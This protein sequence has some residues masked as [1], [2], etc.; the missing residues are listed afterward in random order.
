MLFHSLKKPLFTL[1][2]LLL[3]VTLLFPLMA[4]SMNAVSNPTAGR[5]E[6]QQ[7]TPVYDAPA[8]LRIPPELADFSNPDSE[9]TVELSASAFV[10]LL[11][12]DTL[13]NAESSYLDSML[14][15]RPFQYGNAIPIR[16]VET[17]YE[18]NTLTIIAHPHSYVAVNGE[19]VTWY[20]ASATLGGTN[21]PLRSFGTDG[22]KKCILDN[23]PESES[24]RL[25]VRYTC[26]V[27]V[28]P[29]VADAYINYAWS[30]ADR[31]ANTH[32]AYEAHL[33]A[34]EAYCVYLTEKAA[35]DLAY[36]EWQAYLVA[37][38]KYDK[39]QA[40][41]T[42][43]E[44]AMKVY[45]EQL[46]AYEAYQTALRDY[47]QKQIAYEQ[48]YA[49]YVKELNAYNEA[50]PLYET[51]QAQLQRAADILATLDSAYVFNS[52]GKQM[53]ATLIGDTVA[54]VV[55]RKSE[56]V[57][58]GKCDPK[59]IDT[60]AVS[61]AILQDLLTQYKDI[62]E[63]PDRFAFYRT[64]YSEI[65]RNFIDLYG[66]LRSLYNNEVVKS[67]LIN[68]NKLERF[69]EFLSQLYVISTGLDDTQNRADDWV[70]YGRYDSAYFG[71]KPHTFK[72]ELEPEQIP[73]D[74]NNADPTG[75]TCPP[76]VLPKPT[77]P[78][79]T[80]T[81]PQKP[82]EVIC[83]VEPDPVVK[84]TPPTPIPEPTAPTPVDDPGGKPI[85]PAYTALQ[86]QLMAAHKDGTLRHRSADS[87]APLAL[88]TTLPRQLSLHNK[89]PVE[90]YDYDG[91]TLLFS[92]EL[93]DNAPIAYGG[94]TP[95][96]PDSDKYTYRFVGWK[97][98]DG[99][100]VS[101][102][103]V[104]DE[105]HEVFYASY[106]ATLR[107]Y[108]VTWR[109][110][111]E[112]IDTLLPYGSI[113]S[114]EG[115]P[116]KAPTEQYEYV[117]T[118]WRIPGEDGWSTDLVAILTD[119]TYEAVFEPILRRYTVTWIYGD[120]EADT[121]SA[122]WE[123]GTVPSPDRLPS[124][125][126]DE[127]YLYEFAGWSME[128]SAVTGD[129]SYTAQYTA[130]P[131]LP[132][133]DGTDAPSELP[134]APILHEDVY[135]ATVPTEGLQVDRLVSLALL[136]DRTVT[137]HAADGSLSLDLNHAILSDLQAQRCTYIH[138][139]TAVD[140]S[141]TPHGAASGERCTYS[142]RFLNAESQ[143]IPLTY[144][145]TLRISD[146]NE[147]TKVYALAESGDASTALPATYEAGELTLKISQSMTVCMV[148]EYP[149]TVEPCE[150]GVLTAD[151][152]VYMAGDRVTLSLT[153]AGDYRMDSLRVLGTHT[154]TSYTFEAAADGRFTFL[155]PAEPVTVS[156]S[157]SRMTFTVTFMV[158]DTVISTETYHRGETVRIPA[159]PVKESVGDRVYT[160][161]GWSPII[162]VV[163]ED[164]VYTATFRESEQGGSHT[165]IPPD[166]HNRVYLLFIEA[167]LILAALIAIPVVT[168][169]LVKRRKKKKQASRHDRR[170]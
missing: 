35:Y 64:H 130:I 122:L 153:T 67:T 81:A 101:S 44:Q 47:E 152:S 133:V 32:A 58:V 169:I 57:S 87:C 116:E 148:G 166:S 76:T 50:L 1:A 151:R 63:L 146:A 136:R 92:T 18:H 36:T 69:I 106:E 71:N 142:I 161:I 90:F 2:L 65:C 97:D 48:A 132:V 60:A 120:G 66:S 3:T 24:S 17:T 28:P 99:Q 5:D 126:E 139:D 157:L 34:Y 38:E 42:A 75:E 77:E 117:F 91:Q 104:V 141:S 114:F 74:R 159:D 51:N 86:Q 162:T 23:V 89:R 98:A 156:A 16:T 37:R 29:E 155:M 61:T 41:Y 96:R 25:E 115:T 59:D 119:T 163:T 118:G 103:G 8:D 108:T 54:T 93:D 111:G 68:Y 165:Y 125:A 168:V 72:T 135:A 85:A 4:V 6:I 22:T 128:P 30:Y 52:R 14:A 21:L 9:A 20:P 56:L 10:S 45:R 39:Q 78:V 80:V 164:V 11:T 88:S 149:L 82:S 79:L 137:L 113:P 131:I 55:D 109:I 127:R 83:P 124:R 170:N 94:E 40:A 84:P 31:L 43:Y 107:N 110:D 167:G 121:S 102:L 134:Q 49:T 123:Y 112:A 19:T 26:S 105:S 150:H 27:A 95:L 140:I 138:M 143:P 15:D 70:I 158:G 147:Y 73:P 145:V 144:P 46:A 33:A 12:G 129:Q 13:S 53:Y 160:F 7:D 154:G 62:K 100:L